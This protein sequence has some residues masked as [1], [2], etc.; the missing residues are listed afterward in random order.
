MFNDTKAVRA[1][2]SK[3]GLVSEIADIYLAL[4]VHGPQSISELSR[5]SGIERTR[6]YRLI[7]D[8]TGSSL[9]DVEV[10]YK[11]SIFRA[12][13]IENLEILIAKKEQEIQELHIELPQ[14]QQYLRETS[15]NAYSTRIQYYKGVEGLKQMYWN[16]TKSKSEYLAIL[17]ENMQMRTNLAFFERWVR[18]CNQNQMHFRGIINDNFI[19][20]QQ[21]WYGQHSNERLARW[22]SRYVPENLFTINHSIVIYDDVTSYYSW[23]DG[24]IFGVEMHNQEIADMQRQFFEMLWLQALPVDDLKGTIGNS[25]A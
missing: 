16:Q 11:K 4:Y 1:Y 20:T 3:L 14:L 15:I 6:I 9:V 10:R 7:D 5:R 25:T 8:M 18:A 17:N 12:A 13:P 24:E 21:E 19:K 23:K 2:F 22:Q